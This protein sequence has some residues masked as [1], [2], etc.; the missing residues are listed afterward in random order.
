MKHGKKM[1]A[2]IVITALIVL[3]YIGIMIACMVMPM[4]LWL[5]LV[6]FLVPLLL[7]GTMIGVLVGRIREIK[8]GE[9]DD[10]GKY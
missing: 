4:P 6:F 7:A 10:L 3:Y 2:P 9:E 5:K 1:I 8:G